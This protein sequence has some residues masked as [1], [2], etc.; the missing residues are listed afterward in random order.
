MKLFASLAAIAFAGFAAAQQ[1]QYQIYDMGVLS[2]DTSSQGFRVSTGGVGVGRSLHS[3]GASAIQW[4]QGGGTVALPN[5]SGRAYAVA[6]GANDSGIVVGTGATTAFGSGRLPLIWTNGV[7]SQ[8]ALPSGQTLGDANDV[9]GSGMAV[10]S[11]NAGTLQRGVI[12]SGGSASTI[13][14]T[15]SIGCYFLT[16][17]GVN[18]S[19]L[20]VGQG[21]DPNN[22]AR[23]V[24]IVYDS[25][26]NTAYEVGSLAGMN[27]ALAFD[28]SNSGFVV[29]SAMLNQGSGTPFIWSQAN[30]MSA[31]PLASGTS[32]GSSRGVN[33]AGWVVGNDSGAFSVPFVYN[34][35]T[36]YRIQDVVTVGGAGWDLSANT[37]SSALGISDNGI[38]VGTGVLNGA[39]HGY[40]LV[41]V[42]EPASLAVLGLGLLAAVRR[43]RK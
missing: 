30:G 33:S 14:T 6:N 18:D 20:V 43:P 8:L 38:I 16:A 27:G 12:Y 26:S 35:T 2:G 3:N 24:G 11:C 34:G 40:A 7:V 15:T 9:N 31:I 37:S 36:T 4:T 32:Q 28:V 42:P 23:N 25:V 39:V 41:P 13:T 21:I 29:G 17:F 1:P 19:G 5:L 10:G 22:A